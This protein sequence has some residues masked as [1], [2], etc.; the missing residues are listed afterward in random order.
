MKGFLLKIFNIFIAPIKRYP[1]SFVF[2][3]FLLI[4][5]DLYE[6][7]LRWV[8]NNHHFFSSWLLVSVSVSYFLVTLASLLSKVCRRGGDVL[9]ILF[10]S[11]IYILAFTEIFLYKHF[12]THIN[13]YILQLVDETNFQ[14]SSEFLSTY[15]HTKLFPKL[16]IGFAFLVGL[17]IVLSRF[18]MFIRR[19]NVQ[20]TRS[21]VLQT[22][23]NLLT[24]I[25]GIYTFSALLFLF[26]NHSCFTLNW[27]TNL[28]KDN[29]WE[30]GFAFSFAYRTYQSGLQFLEDKSSIDK[31]AQSLQHISA[32]VRQPKIDNIVIIIGESFN[33]HHSSLYGYEHVTNPR[34]AKLEHLYVFDDV[35][36]PVNNTSRAFKSFLSMASV[37]DKVEWYDTPLFPA[38]FKKVGYNVTFFSNQFVKLPNMSP[39]DASAGFFNHPDVEPHIFSHRNDKKHEYDEGLIEEYQ[40][41]RNEVE[42]DSLNLVFFHLIGQ[43][44]A[45]AKRFPKG[46]DYFHIS[47]Y[48]RKELTEEQVQHVADYDNATLYNDSVVNEIFKLFQNKDALFLYFADHGD[49]ANDYRPYLG[50]CFNLN[51]GGAP[52]LHCQLDIPFLF[53]LTDSCSARHPELE[54]RI[55][56]AR[57]RPFMIDDLPHLLFDVAGIETP[58]YQPTK[59]LINDNYNDD[60]RRIISGFHITEDIDYDAV[61]DGYGEWKIGY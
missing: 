28:E 45:A 4:L 51:E 24:L 32:T 35:I 22:V 17:E 11:L 14:E 47:N 59:S 50:R 37:G 49:E 54:K 33:R 57:H 3:A 23:L 55:A 20:G 25:V 34:L 12:G 2:F 30:H 27:E 36:S 43:H 41:K 13:A 21:T 16:I 39:F 18:V 40:S 56:D 60:H 8:T 6:H 29:V 42:S 53:Y 48:Q 19:L 44:I 26:S 7:R 58:W 15:T 10:H 5:P 61:C 31:C 9:V 52:A 38:I 1:T 46:R